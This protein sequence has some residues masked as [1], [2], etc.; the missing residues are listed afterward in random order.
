MSTANEGCVYHIILG[1]VGK[2][3]TGEMDSMRVRGDHRQRD[4][5]DLQ[6]IGC[7]V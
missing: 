4:V 3:L 7:A 5:W 6:G 2:T 1:S